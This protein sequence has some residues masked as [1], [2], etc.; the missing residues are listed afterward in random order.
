MPP[1]SESNDRLLGRV[2]AEVSEI[3]GDLEAVRDEVKELR[4]EVRTVNERL[5]RMEA[6]SENSRKDLETVIEIMRSFS[7]LLRFAK[8]IAGAI[9]ALAGVREA[10]KQLGWWK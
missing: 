7:T 3:K 5:Q 8:W 10:I 1:T 6:Q 2:E 9:V 4:A